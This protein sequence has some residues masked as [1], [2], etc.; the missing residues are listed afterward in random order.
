M[1]NRRGGAAAL[2]GLLAMAGVTHLVRPGFYDPIVPGALP[3]PPRFW[4]NASVAR[5]GR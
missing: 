3:G 4:T 1:S 2:A 5:A